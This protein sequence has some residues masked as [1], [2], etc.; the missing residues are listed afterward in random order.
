MTLTDRHRDDHV[1][2]DDI[3]DFFTSEEHPLRTIGQ[4]TEQETLEHILKV[5]LLGNC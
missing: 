4:Y 1:D 5:C 3:A 2:I